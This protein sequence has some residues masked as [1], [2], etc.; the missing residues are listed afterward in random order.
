MFAALL[1][2]TPHY[3]QGL[4]ENWEILVFFVGVILLALEIFVIPGFG[5]AGVLGILFIIIGLTLSLIK[6]VPGN[7]P[8][9]LPERNAFVN[10]LFIVIA[11]MVLSIGL[12]FWL[13]GR[14]IKSSMFSKVSV[15][16]VISKEQGFVGVDMTAQ[17]L[18]GKEGSAFT[19]L[20]PSGKVEIEGNVYDATAESGFIEHGEKVTVVKFE[21]AQ[22]F[23]RR[24]IS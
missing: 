21:T 17:N 3:L 22:L 8:I 14:F 6:S 12:S 2:F 18:V 1:Y 16:S 10:A 9:N 11:S 15:Q 19:V 20:R 4:A 23:V 13:F 7:F 5:I 24:S